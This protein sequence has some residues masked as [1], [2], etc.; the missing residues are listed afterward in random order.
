MSTPHSGVAATAPWNVGIMRRY[1]ALS[2]AA[3][4]LFLGLMASAASSAAS[5]AVSGDLGGNDVCVPMAPDF[6]D[7]VDAN[8]VVHPNPDP[9]YATRYH[10][11]GSRFSGYQI[12][13]PPGWNPVTASDATLK[14]FGLPPRPTDPAALAEWTDVW[15]KVKTFGPPGKMCETENSGD[16]VGRAAARAA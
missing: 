7:Y 6:V 12:Q 14:A 16:I 8:G 2:T 10:Y 9:T 13:P 3:L 11:N 15:S 1:V 4:T 5:P